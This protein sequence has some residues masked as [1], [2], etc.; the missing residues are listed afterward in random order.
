MAI[1]ERVGDVLRDR[2]DYVATAESCTGG[3]IGS[4]ITDVPG[5]SDYFDRAYVTYTY[6]A[7]LQ[8]LGVPRETLDDVGAVSAPVARSMARA[9]RDCAG[10]AWGVATTGIAGPTGG[11]EEKPVGTVHIGVARAAPW[12][13]GDSRCTVDRYEFDGTRTEIKRKIA[14]QA[15]AD[16]VTAAEGA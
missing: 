13:T 15:L 12:D 1:E 2:G 6:D 9:A 11:T 5:A 8:E 10:V 16:L 14:E 3:L 4:L 7:K